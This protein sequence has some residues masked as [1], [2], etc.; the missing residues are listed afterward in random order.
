MTPEFSLQRKRWRTHVFGGNLW[1]PRNPALLSACAFSLLEVCGGWSSPSASA[2]RSIVSIMEKLE[3]SHYYL[4]ISLWVYFSIQH[5]IPSTR[6]FLRVDPLPVL[7]CHV[8]FLWASARFLPGCNSVEGN[9]SPCSTV[10]TWTGKGHRWHIIHSPCSL[11]GT[12]FQKTAAL[13]GTDWGK[14]TNLFLNRGVS[15][16]TGIAHC[17]AWTGG[18]CKFFYNF[19]KMQYM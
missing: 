7:L 5:R 1:P 6:L 17:M 13:H 15:L 18:T 2:A 10:S 19:D 12:I 4:K 8:Q 16:L 14:H 9:H 11:L 3:Q